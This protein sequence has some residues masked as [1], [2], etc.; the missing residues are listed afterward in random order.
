[1]S[2]LDAHLRR[3]AH[4]ITVY[5]FR[6]ESNMDKGVNASVDSCENIDVNCDN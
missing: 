6:H 5:A 2:H 4:A 3:T 1:M